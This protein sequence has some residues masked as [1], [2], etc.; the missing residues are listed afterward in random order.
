MSGVVQLAAEGG[1]HRESTTV[2][3]LLAVIA[4]GIGVVAITA[5]A[6][7]IRFSAPL[8]IVGVAV[9][10][11]LVPGVPAF[12]LDPDLVLF[13]LLPPLLYAAARGNSYLGVQKLRRPIGMLAV[14]MVIVTAL[15]VGV[16]THLIVPDV[17]WAAAIAL[18]AVVG[19]P[20]AVA[21]TAVARR[22]GLPRKLVTVLE[23]ESLFNDATALVT[24]RV[25][26]AAAVGGTF[27]LGDT[28]LQFLVAAVGG[29]AFG[30]VAGLLL[31]W[32]RARMTSA[33][34]T[35][36]LSLL[37]P[38]AVYVAAEEAT[39]SGVIAV[40]VTGLV[41]A[42]RSPVDQSPAA[43]LTENGVWATSQLLLEGVVFALVG[44][45]LTS[46][47]AGVTSP[48]STVALLSGVVLLTVLV[49]RPLWV[50]GL[51][52]V[53][54]VLPWTRSE[55]PKPGGL[56]VI[57]WAGMR[58]VVS[59]AAAQTLPLD[60]P[61][62][63]LFLLATM[64]VIF[65]TLGLQGLTL[66]AL[67]RRVGVE[68]PDPPA[69]RLPGRAGAA[70]G[71]R[72]RQAQDRGDRRGGRAAAAAGAADAQ[73]ARP[74]RVLRLGAARRPAGGD[75]HADVP[76]AAQG[77]RGGRAGGVRRAARHRG[78]RGGAAARAA[79]PARPGGVAA[80]RPGRVGGRGP[81]G[82]AAGPAGPYL[83]ASAGRAGRGAGR[84]AAR[85]RG[86]PPRRPRRLG[87][88]ARLPQLRARRVLRLVAWEA[89]GRALHRD[90]PP[91]DG[92]G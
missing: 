92:L 55:R 53:A 39:L 54:R 82:R 89:L 81:P 59:L 14:G 76:A 8:L 16:V 21:A 79:A 86:L 37:T 51:V 91:G 20:D 38:F 23:G 36:G 47:V 42:H 33:L 11:S 9:A 28:V 26:I 13:V 5:L 70:A 6:Q 25:S 69:G 87:A 3:T 75:P 74:A 73:A 56:A 43:R 22:A 71:H 32:V 31:S 78:A 45:Q 52:Y 30:T 17:S 60:L 80:A 27:A 1:G 10:V 88:P 2:S 24:L 12:Q 18:G 50:F 40:V 49:V 66:P 90:R 58:G 67:I 7:R 34:L 85:V 57:S 65:G 63:D 83:R 72:R 68:A 61:H 64:V 35:T 19:P 15:S 41:L 46:I 77:D 62:R 44:L 48:W 4:V 84:R 29:L